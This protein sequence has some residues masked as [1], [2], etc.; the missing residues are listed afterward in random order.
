MAGVI[1]ASCWD[2]LLN[3]LVGDNGIGLTMSFLGHFAGQFQ[4]I[5]DLKEEQLK[6][7]VK[8]SENAA[9][10]KPLDTWRVTETRVRRISPAM[11]NLF[12]K[13]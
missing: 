3:N 8:A 11:T 13:C 2:I 6:Q 4:H 10:P 5:W 12:C 7:L 1:T 9:E